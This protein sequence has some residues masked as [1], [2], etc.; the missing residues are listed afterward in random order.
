M[1]KQV[2]E[3]PERSEKQGFLNLE[4]YP[5]KRAR[6]DTGRTAIDPSLSRR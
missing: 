1:P 4:K 5:E 3:E 6:V 2:V